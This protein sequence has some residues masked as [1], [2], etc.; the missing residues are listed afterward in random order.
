M[1]DQLAYRITEREPELI[2][3]T[4]RGIERVLEDISGPVVPPD[5]L[6]DVIRVRRR[7]GDPV[8]SD[9]IFVNT[10]PAAAQPRTAV[11]TGDGNYWFYNR[12]EWKPYALKFS[13]VYIR[14][15]IKERGQRPAAIR[16]IDNLIARIDPTDYITSGN[17]GG[18]SVSFPTIAEVMD[19]YHRRRDLLLKEEA[20]DAGMNSG[21]ML[22]TIRRP[23]GGVLEGDEPWV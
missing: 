1:P 15:L 9:F 2:R 13:D 6:Q 8:T 21:L 22:K 14:E 17:A 16:L 12:I 19:F 5:W 20:E 4:E 10:L 7:I 11:T 23:V 3:L 18:Q